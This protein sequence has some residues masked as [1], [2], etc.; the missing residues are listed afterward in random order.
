MTAPQPA[1]QQSFP[2]VPRLTLAS[3][4]RGKMVQPPRLFVYGVEG[5]G[6]STLGA[7]A[8]KPIILGVEDGT[9]RIDVPR[10]PMP[11]GGMQLV[12]VFDAISELTTGTHDF[13]TLVID[14]V[15]W[16]EPLVWDFIC[17]R[18]D[19][20]NVEGYGYGKGYQVAL[21]EWRRLLSALEKLRTTKKMGVLLLG[22]S[23]IKAFKNPEGDDFDRY[24]LKV[25]AKA[26]GLLKE[27]CDAVL[28]ANY[29]TFAKKAAK[30]EKNKYAKSKGVSTGARL[31][32]TERTAAYDAKNRYGLP[33]QL[34]LSWAELEAA[35]AAGQ[36]VDPAVAIEAINQKLLQ[37]PAAEQEKARAVLVRAGNDSTKLSLLNNIINA[38]LTAA[39]KEG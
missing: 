34:P 30:D 1:K 22:H 14:T 4:V 13:Q 25:H 38:A 35:M 20:P 21:D 27:W 24:E 2:H 32:F 19:Q 18:D 28:F 3:V 29:E 31:L 36:P 7:G 16:L 11:D 10:F 37:L 33:S 26:G 39:N 5:I 9:G 6:K 12:D 8:P 15:D 17:R 23:L